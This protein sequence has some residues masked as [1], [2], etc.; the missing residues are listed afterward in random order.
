[1]FCGV[2]KLTFAKTKKLT[3]E[4]ETVDVRT[5]TTDLPQT[6]TQLPPDFD[7]RKQQKKI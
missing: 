3:N 5:N 4:G 1:M 6:L 2:T 7:W